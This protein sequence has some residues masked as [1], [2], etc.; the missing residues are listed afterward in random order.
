MHLCSFIL[1]CLFPFGCH[2]HLYYEHYVRIAFAISFLILVGIVE[3]FCVLFAHKLHFRL[4][5]IDH[6]LYIS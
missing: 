5:D 4:G 1:C 2:D 3:L 6:Q